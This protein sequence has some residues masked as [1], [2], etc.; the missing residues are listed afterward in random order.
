MSTYRQQ[1]LVSVALGISF[2]AAQF[3]PFYVH[4]DSTGALAA[5]ANAA[6]AG[7]GDGD[8]FE[9]TP[10]SA[11]GINDNNFA[12]SANTG[13]G[14]ATDGCATFN[15]AEDDAHDYF[16]FGTSIPAGSV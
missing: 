9:T 10:G 14:N 6:V 3:F 12:V 2:L 11:D 7:A 13:S 8:G 15:Q 1:T 5:G 4:A 16:N